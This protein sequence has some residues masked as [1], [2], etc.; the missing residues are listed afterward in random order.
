[1]ISIKNKDLK[2]E[3][4]S[5]YN[6]GKS[7]IINPDG[8]NHVT[9]NE[10]NEFRKKLQLQKIKSYPEFYQ[11]FLSILN[12]DNPNLDLFSNKQIYD[13]K[14]YMLGEVKNTLN[15]PIG[16]FVSYAKIREN[17]Y[18]RIKLATYTDSTITGRMKI[19]DGI[20][21][22][23]I[24]KSH[25]KKYF[26]IDKNEKLVE[27][28]FKSCEP[29]F[30]CSINN[31]SIEKDLYLDIIEKFNLENNREKIKRGILTLIYGGSNNLVRQFIK[32]DVQNIE[33]IK[34]F[35]KID[36]FTQMI[37]RNIG[38]NDFMLNHYGRPILSI[39][40]PLN[41]Y[42]QSSTA[43]FCCFAFEN[44]LKNEKRIKLHALIHDA[45]IISCYKN[46]FKEIINKYKYL[47]DPI[48]KIK[49]PV[50]IKEI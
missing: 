9:I 32:T 13:Y 11:K 22:L 26:S 14:K 35:L 45:I 19:T 12:T 41:Y 33:K 47:I 4:N 50:S 48:T 15:Y 44:F 16:Y 25:R 3:I 20:N 42:I 43:D 23:T 8:D 28:D 24:K 6:F 21:F 10:L 18:T 17:L 38:E 36:S 7:I 40:N 30:Y 49:I 5:D 39:K 27:I 31:I 34:E 37:N 46:D 2:I 29:N 1:M